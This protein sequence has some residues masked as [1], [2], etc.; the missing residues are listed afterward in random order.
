MS[1]DLRLFALSESQGFGEAVASALDT[2]LQPHH[3]QT[4]T[5]GEHEVRPEVNVRGRDAFVVQSLYGTRSGASTT[6]CAA[7]CLCSGR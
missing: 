3:E 5:D 4:F 6:S 2:P 1:H 7:C